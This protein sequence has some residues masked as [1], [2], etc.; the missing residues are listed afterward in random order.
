VQMALMGLIQYGAVEVYGTEAG[1]APG[2]PVIAAPDHLDPL[3][4]HWS[5]SGWLVTRAGRG[6]GAAPGGGQLG[7]GQAGLRLAYLLVPRHRIAAFARVAAPLK[8]EGSE[9]AIGLEWQPGR[10]PVRLVVERRFGVDGTP[11]G[12][13]LG[14]IGGLDAETAGFR[15]EAYGQAGAI[16]RRRIEPYADGAARL[17]RRVGPGK[18]RLSLGAGAWGAAQRDA[19]RLDLGPSAVLA[20][21]RVRLSLDWRQRIAGNARPGSG[22]ALTLGSDF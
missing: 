17:T 7:G 9:V 8:A 14:L 13:G 1:T 3:P 15:I 22:L 12:T 11:G 10:A 20:L 4:D 6:I 19:E 16:A 2:A 5:A 21:D 18:V